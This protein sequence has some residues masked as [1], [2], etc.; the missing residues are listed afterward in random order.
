MATIIK[1]DSQ[2]LFKMREGYG[3]IGAQLNLSIVHLWCIKE[4][5]VMAKKAIEEKDDHLAAQVLKN[6]MP[7]LNKFKDVEHPHNP[8]LW[9][10]S[11][12]NEL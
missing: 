2:P 9:E 4:W 6:M 1:K 12:V 7:F 10:E 8:D 11:E 3:V 5:Q